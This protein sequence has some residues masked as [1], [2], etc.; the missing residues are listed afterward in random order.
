M[1]KRGKALFWTLIGLSIVIA[2]VIVST[3]LPLRDNQPVYNGRTLT[4]WLETTT[5][6]GA[7][8]GS[9]TPQ[10]VEAAEYAVRAI[11]TNA[12]PFL[13]KWTQYKTSSAKRYFFG[14]FENTPMPGYLRGRLWGLTH[15][16]EE[17]A[18]LGVQGFRL[19]HTNAFA[20][21]ALSKMA[22]DTNNPWMQMPAAKALLTVTNTTTR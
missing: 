4:Q 22:G 7:N 6:I 11:G 18:E 3:I 19:L 9:T 12:F 16:R 21:E 10:Q 14:V 13:V 5:R 2:V 1:R 15:R 17:L 8:R 20:F